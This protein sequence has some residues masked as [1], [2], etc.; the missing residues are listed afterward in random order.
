MAKFK[1]IWAPNSAYGGI[2]WRVTSDVESVK[3][4]RRDPTK[5]ETTYTIH[6]AT[7]RHMRRNLLEK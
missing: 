7:A 4:G 1:T 3:V 2:E 6:I 5:S